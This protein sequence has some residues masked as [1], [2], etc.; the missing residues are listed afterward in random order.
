MPKRGGTP[1]AERPRKT[2]TEDKGMSHIIALTLQ[3]V[4]RKDAQ[5]QR[6]LDKEHAKRESIAQADKER[7]RKKETARKASDAPTKS[8]IME[9]LREQRRERSRERKKK[10]KAASDAET[11]A[12]TTNTKAKK[13]VTMATPEQQSA[14]APRSN[15]K[16]SHPDASGPAKPK[17]K[18]VSF[19]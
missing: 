7:A 17:K 2:F 19:G 9:D 16:K 10:R 13:R 12:P 6:V 11:A 4:D 18:R 8:S 14:P 5:Y 3:A 1:K 15:L